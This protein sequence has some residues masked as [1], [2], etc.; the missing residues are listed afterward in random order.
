MFIDNDIMPYKKKKK[1]QV[2]KS[3]HK[4]IYE[5]CIIKYPRDIFNKEHGFIKDKIESIAKYCPICG[6]IQNNLSPDDWEKI[7]VNKN[8]IYNT[9]I[10]WFPY[11]K[12]EYLTEYAKKQINPKT[13][14]IP[15]FEIKNFWD[16]K[17]NIKTGEN[18]D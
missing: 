7:T 11:V 14:T 3:N 5:F 12:E 16:K 17:V 18:N 9:S 4:H 10:Y 8:F 13:R 2:K 1:K 6:K 15:S